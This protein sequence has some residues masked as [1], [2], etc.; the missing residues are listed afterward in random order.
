[1]NKYRDIQVIKGNLH[2]TF[3]LNNI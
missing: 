2:V 3:R 1:M